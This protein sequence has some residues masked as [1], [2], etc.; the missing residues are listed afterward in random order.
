MYALWPAVFDGTVGT[1]TIEGNTT[2]SPVPYRTVP[3]NTAGHIQLLAIF[4]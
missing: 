3:S 2:P 1:G 4:K